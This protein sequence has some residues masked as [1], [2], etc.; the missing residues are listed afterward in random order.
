M[1][2]ILVYDIV[3]NNFRKIAENQMTLNGV[4]R[5]NVKDIAEKYGCSIEFR[6]S[7]I[8]RDSYRRMF[9]RLARRED[10]HEA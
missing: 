6:A 8:P 7:E 1:E 2:E 3:S 10:K 5:P 4:N 9:R